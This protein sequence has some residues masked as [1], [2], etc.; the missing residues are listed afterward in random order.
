MASSAADRLNVEVI[1]SGTERKL[2]SQDFRGGKIA[3]VFGG[4]EI[5]LREVATTQQEIVI[6]ADAVFG[7]VELWVPAN[8]KVDVRGSGVFGVYE[9]KTSVQQPLD[10]NAPRLIIRGGAVFGSVTVEN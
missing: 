4:A 6:Q 9:D 10:S 3:A 8:W 2:V 5:D 7:G 1:F